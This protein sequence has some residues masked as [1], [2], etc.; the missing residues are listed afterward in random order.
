M[1]FKCPFHPKLFYDS[2]YFEDFW[3]F[4][5]GECVA[6][7]L[8]VHQYVLCGMVLRNT[9]RPLGQQLWSGLYLLALNQGLLLNGVLMAQ[10]FC[11]LTRTAL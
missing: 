6:K 5:V 8:K 1:T 9:P 10:A 4:W 3:T 11:L 7:N 2:E